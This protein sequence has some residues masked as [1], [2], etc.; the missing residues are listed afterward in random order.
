M[1]LRSMVLFLAIAV[2][3]A[4]LCSNYSEREVQYD[5]D[6]TKALEVVCGKNF[7]ATGGV[8]GLQAI[9][10][11]EELNGTRLLDFG[12]GL[13]GPAMLLAEKYEITVFAVDIEPY[14]INKLRGSLERIE[15][16][17]VVIPKLILPNEELPFSDNSFDRIYAGESI[18]HVD[19]RAKRGLFAEF[20]RVLKKNG[21]IIINDWVHSSAVYTE[22]LKA[23]SVDNT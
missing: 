13:G 2:N 8:Q 18:L 4:V 3:G 11:N 12:C 5:A 16:K 22:E 21:V 7:L 19:V 17:G 6:F 15:L 10:R 23:F 14:V 1:Y 20:Y 9:F